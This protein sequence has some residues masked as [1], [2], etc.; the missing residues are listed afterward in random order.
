M[1]N[2]TTFLI[3]V[4]SILSVPAQYVKEEPGNFNTLQISDKIKVVLVPSNKTMVEVSGTHAEKVQISNKGG[5]LSLSLPNAESLQGEMT[6]ANIYFKSLESIQADNGAI[7]ICTSPIESYAMNLSVKNRSDVY[8]YLKTINV[9]IDLA[10]NSVLKLIGN[11]DN[12]IINSKDNS[13]IKARDFITKKTTITLQADGNAQ[14]FASDAVNAKVVS[15][16]FI[17]VYGP[18]TTV[19]QNAD[20]SGTITIVQ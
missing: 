9:T 4:F 13:E 10:N 14:V 12:Q 18:P 20:G 17:F 1:Q 16:G 11:S 6:Q 19:T 15:S 3:F 8:L 7:I 2:I 5:K